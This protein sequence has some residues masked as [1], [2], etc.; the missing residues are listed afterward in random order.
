MAMYYG[1][2][3]AAALE[4]LKA[5]YDP[6]NTFRYPQSVPLASAAP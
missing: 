1:T 4:A 6:L 3:N 5:R 2:E